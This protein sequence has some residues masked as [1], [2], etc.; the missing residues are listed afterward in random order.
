MNP[1]L[2][3]LVDFE[4]VEEIDAIP[5]ALRAAV[6]TKGPLDLLRSLG[7]FVGRL[8]P[9]YRREALRFAVEVVR[10]RP[11]LATQIERKCAEVVRLAGDA[12]TP[13]S[14]F[15]IKK[16]IIER[17]QRREKSQRGQV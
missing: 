16:A 8:P 9:A 2:V 13:V 5:S 15:R 10:H 12:V 6:T 11:D 14:Y 4:T 7:T 3:G 17:L 1:L